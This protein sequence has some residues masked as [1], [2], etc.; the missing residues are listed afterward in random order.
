MSSLGELGHDV[1]RAVKGC[2]Q[3]GLADD[4]GGRAA[5]LSSNV[6]LFREIFFQG[7]KDEDILICSGNMYADALSASAAGKPILLVNTELA[8]VQK[9]YLSTLNTENLFV[10]GGAGV[11]PEQVR[12]DAE[13]YALLTSIC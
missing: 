7:V 3:A 13:K 4:V 6:Q 8:P 2:G 11:V 1:A 10:I 9:A 5:W 12:A